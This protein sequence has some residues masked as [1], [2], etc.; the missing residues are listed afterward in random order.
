MSSIK[1]TTNLSCR[2]D[3]NV[4]DI[5]VKDA[6]SKGISLNSLVNSISKRYISWE[7]NAE[8]IGFIPLAKETVG[9]IF[10]KLDDKDIKEIAYDVGSTIPKEFI[11]LTYGHVSFPNIL[12]MIEIGNSRFGHIKHD[13]DY[14]THHITI[15]HGINEKF[16]LFLT[17][18]HEAMA[19][20]L[21]VHLKIT[22]SDC[23][24]ISMEIMENSFTK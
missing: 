16:S 22:S 13:I 5:L 2:L 8:K 12:S 9:H 24:M 1:K 19:K 17:Y 11:M 10:E 15:F 6:E 21:S 14:N 7:K 23:S 3:K 4:Y 18:V 20:D